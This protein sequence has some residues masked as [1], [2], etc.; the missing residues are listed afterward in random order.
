M[1]IFAETFKQTTMAKSRAGRK[2]KPENEK[3]SHAYRLAYTDAQ[4][5]A[6]KAESK[7]MLGVV[8]VHTYLKATILKQIN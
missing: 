3:L 1:L 8:D 7:K 2:P 6:L 5:E 4:N